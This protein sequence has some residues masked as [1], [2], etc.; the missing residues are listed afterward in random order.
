MNELMLHANEIHLSAMGEIRTNNWITIPAQE[1]VRRCVAALKSGEAVC[2]R[3]RRQ[4][5]VSFEEYTVSI[6]ATDYS[7]LTARRKH[8]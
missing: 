7:I 4:W 5:E 6:R 8:G 1:L 3:R 2:V